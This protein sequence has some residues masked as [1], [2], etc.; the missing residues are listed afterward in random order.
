MFSPP[1][2]GRFNSLTKKAS[3]TLGSLTQKGMQQVVLPIGHASKRLATCVFPSGHDIEPKKQDDLQKVLSP[4]GHT[5]P[6]LKVPPIFLSFSLKKAIFNR[7]M[8]GTF[9]EGRVGEKGS[10]HFRASILG[11]LRIFPHVSC[12]LLGFLIMHHLEASKTQVLGRN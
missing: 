7:K 6:S 11:A 2:F 1:F 9:K 8:G 5:L 3:S 10:R 4:I 12:F